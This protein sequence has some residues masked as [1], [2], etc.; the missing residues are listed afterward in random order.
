MDV[1]WSWVGNQPARPVLDITRHFYG[2][3]V[4]VSVGIS[5][6]GTDK[7]QVTPVR[8][9]D[10]YQAAISFCLPRGTC[11]DSVRTWL[12]TQLHLSSIYKL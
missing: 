5:P 10:D 4:P 6:M 8:S 7:A 3:A 2:L 11:V 12:P 9:F 1:E